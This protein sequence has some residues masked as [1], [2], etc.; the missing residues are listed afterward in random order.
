MFKRL[1]PRTVDFLKHFDLAAENALKG[2][3]AF[4]E[5]MRDYTDVEFKVQQIKAIEHEGDRITHAT[6][7]ELN[8][9]FITP[10]DREDIVELISRLDDILDIIDGAAT[11]I[12]TYRI[13][14][15]TPQ[16]KG[17]SE[18]LIR[19]IEVVQEA[20]CLL[21][22]MKNSKKILECCVEINRLE[23]EADALYRAAVGELFDTEKDP[24]KVIKLK[25]I[26]DILELA[27]DRCEDVAN[28]IETVVI[29][30]S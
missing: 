24:I 14:E 23:N 12:Q 11:R 13:A 21:G 9:T 25:E 28:I 27:S 10:I 3:R 17:I 29:K 4:S 1:F 19:P 20:L 22:D 7:D 6:I 26:Y 15:V 8:R 16:L 18:Q 2:A 30:N 5:L